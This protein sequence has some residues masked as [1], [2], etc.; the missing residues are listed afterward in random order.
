[1]L[2]RFALA[3]SFTILTLVSARADVVGCDTLS[4][5]PHDKKSTAD[6]V[7]YEELRS[8]ADDAIAACRIALE[9]A[10]DNP[11]IQYQLGRALLASG[12]NEDA[13][14]WISTSANQGYP[15]AMNAYA[16]LLNHGRGTQKDIK[17]AVQLISQ[18]AELGNVPAMANMGALYSNI[19]GNNVSGLVDRTTSQKWLHM[20]AAENDPLAMAR[21]GWNYG[22]GDG[23]VTADKTL[24]Y[25]F[26]DRALAVKEE[27]A[28]YI[29]IVVAGSGFHD[30]AKAEQFENLSKES[31]NRLA[32]VSRHQ[33]K[34]TVELIEDIELIGFRFDRPEEEPVYVREFIFD[35][36]EY[37]AQIMDGTLALMDPDAKAAAEKFI[38]QVET[39][40]AAVPSMSEP[41]KSA[42]V[43]QTASDF[44]QRTECDGL[45]SSPSDRL[46]VAPP[47]PYATLR[48][49]AAEA[50][51]VCA[52]AVEQDPSNVRAKY[53]L[54][55][56]YIAQGNDQKGAVS[57]F[58][59]AIGNYPAAMNAFGVLLNHG[60]G[61]NV[62]YRSSFKWLKKAAESGNP[63]AAINLAT[64]Y[65]MGLGTQLDAD[66]GTHWTKVGAELK[67]P[68]ALYTLG[69]GHTM[70]SLWYRSVKVRRDIE[71]GVTYLLEAQD[72]GD[73]DA[74]YALHMVSC[75]NCEAKTN[76]PHLAKKL[77]DPEYYNRLAEEMGDRRPVMNRLVSNSSE[78]TQ[79]IQAIEV[80]RQMPNP[81][82][83]PDREP[84]YVVDAYQDNEYR[85]GQF[86][87]GAA[88]GQL[89]V[90]TELTE[91]YHRLVESNRSFERIASQR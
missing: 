88:Q 75:S 37:H 14:K 26:I 28:Y 24:A 72:L 33:Y 38:E 42:E 61:L 70:V 83:E 32:L 20:A 7:S 86:V 44:G 34:Y 59:A 21:L 18:A 8:F 79:L 81:V 73:R 80:I 10:P 52:A 64:A 91:A 53:L 85:L 51:R 36:D 49:H 9:N 54:G 74:V 43:Q 35:Q 27:S 17:K 45:A 11:R 12:N 41:E 19:A 62:D 57:L 71:K 31:K 23:G 87:D 4:A 60:R 5:S 65:Y 22:M 67:D 3:L 30:A 46:A 2:R 66:K 90:H 56:A 50:V 84:V 78:P 76:F 6:S 47:V 48:A 69:A 25:Q 68:K 40:N 39:K 1:M 82:D 15:V 16:V 13:V 77:R 89:G 63:P 55:R 29:A 58:N